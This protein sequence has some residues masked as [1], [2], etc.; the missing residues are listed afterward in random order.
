MPNPGI[1]RQFEHQRNPTELRPAGITDLQVRLLK[2]GREVKL[3]IYDASSMVLLEFLSDEVRACVA[4]FG[5][6]ASSRPLVVLEEPR[7]RNVPK[8]SLDGDRR[9]EGL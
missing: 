7:L 4:L 5:G 1:G 3:P 8:G 9:I 2:K 6:H